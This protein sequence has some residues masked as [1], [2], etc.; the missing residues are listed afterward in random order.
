MELLGNVFNSIAISGMKLPGLRS[1]CK[2][3]S[4][5]NLNKYSI[6]AALIIILC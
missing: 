4:G 5:T 6:K 1:Q 3:H 2:L